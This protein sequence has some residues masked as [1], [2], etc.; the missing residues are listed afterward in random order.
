MS[1]VTI[2]ISV[3]LSLKTCQRRLRAPRSEKRENHRASRMEKTGSYLAQKRLLTKFTPD[4]W[5]LSPN[6]GAALVPVLLVLESPPP[7]PWPTS[8]PTS[9]HHSAVAVSITKSLIHGRLCHFCA[10]GARLL[11]RLASVR[12]LTRCPKNRRAAANKRRRRVSNQRTHAQ[13]NM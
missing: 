6:G 11:G 13:E 2:C 10:I 9:S 5:W 8:W 3:E 7:W 12:S 4:D 1:V